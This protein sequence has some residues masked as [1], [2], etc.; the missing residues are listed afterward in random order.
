MWSERLSLCR[1]SL[2]ASDEPIRGRISMIRQLRLG[3]GV[4]LLAILPVAAQPTPRVETTFNYS[5]IRFEPNG[6]APTFHA[7]G[8]NFQLV[9]NFNNWLGLAGDFGGYRAGGLAGYGWDG[10]LA[11][12][13]AGP[14]V[15]FLRGKRL[16]PFAQALFGGAWIS[17]HEQ[18]TAAPVFANL[19]PLAGSTTKFGMLAGVGM[20]IRVSRH[21]AIR[22]F[23]ADYFRTNLPNPV[24]T[25][26]NITTNIRLS[27]GLSLLFGGEKPH[28][29]SPPPPAMKA[30]PDG[31]KVPAGSPCPKMPLNVQ[32]NGARAQ[33]CQGETMPLASALSANHSDVNFQWTVNGQ[34]AGHGP[35]FA[36]GGVEPGTYRVGVTASGNAYETATHDTTIAVLEK[37][38]PSGSVQATPSEM[39]A[40]GK[41]S[42]SASFAGQCCEPISTPNFSASEG[43]VAGTEFDSSTVRFDPN[44]RSEQRRVV[45]ITAKVMDRCNNEG[46]ATT[47][48]TVVQKATVAPVRLP[49]VLFP[50]GSSRVNN[51]G[52]RVLLENLRTYFERDPAGR[53][54]L[55][56]HIATNEA[57]KLAEERARNA[58][59]VITAGSGVCL[60]LPADQVLVSAPGAEQ[61][62]VDF[63]PNF[64]GPSVLEQRG[65]AVQASD[66]MAQYRRV[67]VWFVPSG[68]EPPKSLGDHQAASALRI[69]SCPK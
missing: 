24:Y 12:Y 15:S 9:Y 35:T 16:N 32:I 56:G 26:E 13:L 44:D 64:C 57:A 19:R 62:D 14:R 40:G 6:L 46:T 29:P 47:S 1:E 3:L 39:T 67:E 37:R 45:T 51:C 20:D 60:S 33:M 7:N 27:A 38:A 21:L 63:K 48:V 11:N 34:P 23:E 49:D 18:V 22:A 61:R 30:C 8:G 54:V 41:A 53:A 52:K 43:S 36:F 4:S 59:A 55:V 10:T 2:I 65:A 17:S 31:S 42:L 66:R 5:Y 50:A 28:P 68:A 58:A 25:G 69:T